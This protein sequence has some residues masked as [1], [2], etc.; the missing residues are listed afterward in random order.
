MKSPSKTDSSHAILYELQKMTSRFGQ[1]EK[2]AA[3]DGTILAGLVKRLDEP[4][5]ME[6]VLTIPG[7]STTQGSTTQNVTI[8]VRH[9]ILC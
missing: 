3:A 9:R 8:K 6:N 7:Q 2:Q 1:I 5:R 4:Q